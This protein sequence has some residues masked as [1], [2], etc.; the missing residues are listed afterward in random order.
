[1]F[2]AVVKHSED[3]NWNDLTPNLAEI[4][5]RRGF[6]VRPNGIET[7]YSVKTRVPESYLSKQEKL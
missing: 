3:E 4:L 5:G 2:S 7:K 1:V 6:R